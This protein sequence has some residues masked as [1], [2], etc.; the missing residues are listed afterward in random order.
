MHRYRTLFLSDIHLGARDCKADLLLA[1]L[2]QVKA[3]RI[4]LLG[5]IVD[6]WALRRVSH[7]SA[8]H[9]AVLQ[10]LQALAEQGTR[11]IYIPGNHDAPLRQFTGRFPAGIEVTQQA[12]H[13]TA[14]GKQ[15]LLIHGDCFDEAMHCAPWLYWLGD[16]AYELLLFLNRCNALLARL[17]GTPY[18]SLAGFIKQRIGK[19]RQL[20]DTFQ[21]LALDLARSRACDGIVCGH[22]HHPALVQTDGLTYANC[23]DWVESCTLLVETPSGSLQLLS[24]ADLLARQ[25]QAVPLAEAA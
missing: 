17:R 2:Q 22:I 19:A 23:G 5:D 20:L 10:H 8:S 4:Y 15:L 13:T 7:W 12:C 18:W 24:A 14:R 11:I 25:N 9:S 3:D 21:S 1:C 6:L 16:R